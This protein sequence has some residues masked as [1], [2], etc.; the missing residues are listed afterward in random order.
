MLHSEISDNLPQIFS[1][2]YRVQAKKYPIIDPFHI[3]SIHVQIHYTH[4]IQ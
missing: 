4:W 1:R 3:L 2:H